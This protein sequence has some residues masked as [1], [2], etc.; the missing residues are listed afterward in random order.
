MECDENF[1]IVEK[2]MC[3]SPMSGQLLLTRESFKNF[4]VEEMRKE[5]FFSFGNLEGVVNA[6]KKY[7]ENWEKKCEDLL[8]GR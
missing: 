3:S 6:F 4:T 2:D 5:N 8:G 7:L 1:A